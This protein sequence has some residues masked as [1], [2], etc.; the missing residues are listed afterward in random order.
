MSRMTNSPVGTVASARKSA[1]G[2]TVAG[3]IPRYLSRAGVAT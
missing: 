3:S 1:L 2:S